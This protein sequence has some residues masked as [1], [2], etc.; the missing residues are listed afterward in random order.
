MQELHCMR[1]WT[2]KDWDWLPLNFEL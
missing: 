2:K 1:K